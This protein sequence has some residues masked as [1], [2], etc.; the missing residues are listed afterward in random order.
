[1]QKMQHLQESPIEIDPVEEE[2]NVPA[3]IKFPREAG[4]GEVEQESRKTV[5]Q[6]TTQCKAVATYF[7]N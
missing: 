2:W 3:Y 1:M 6:I 5:D 4:E 7:L